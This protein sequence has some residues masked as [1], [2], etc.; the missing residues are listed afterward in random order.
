METKEIFKEKLK[1]PSYTIQ[2]QLRRI[3]T[4]QMLQ[5][6]VDLLRSN[7]YSHLLNLWLVNLYQKKEHTCMLKYTFSDILQ[8]SLQIE[9][10]VGELYTKKHTPFYTSTNH[11]NLFVILSY[12]QTCA[13]CCQNDL[14]VNMFFSKTDIDRFTIWSNITEELPLHPSS[15]NLLNLRATVFAQRKKRYS[16]HKESFL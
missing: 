12:S 16:G 1:E 13:E 5:R 8:S 15:G 6:W 3:F 4:M 14:K 7:Y 2:Q 10:S 11:T 9:K